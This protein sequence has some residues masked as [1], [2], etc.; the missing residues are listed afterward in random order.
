[1]QAATTGERQEHKGDQDQEL[2]VHAQE[3][4]VHHHQLLLWRQLPGMKLFYNINLQFITLSRCSRT[5][6]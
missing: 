1:M 2:S 4:P 3:L 6:L 5:A